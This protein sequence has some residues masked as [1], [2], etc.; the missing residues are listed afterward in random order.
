MVSVRVRRRVAVMARRLSVA[1]GCCA[2]FALVLGATAGA[3]APPPSKRAGAS[4]V[5]VG[6]SRAQRQLA[7]LAALR[8]GGVTIRRVVFQ[9]PSRVL[10]YEHVRGVELVVSSAG[11]RT[12]RAEWEQ[13]LY[14]GAYLGLMG[15]WPKAA[16][17][18]A[19]TD[20]TEG[21]VG[22]L[23]P[24]EVFGS[25]PCAAAVQR[26]LVPLSA[27]ASRHGAR[28]VELRVAATPAR[29]IAL[30]LRVSDPAAFLKHWT[31]PVLRLLE[32][33]RIPLLGYY[34]GV[35]EAS[36]RLVFATSRLPDTGAVFVIPS[37]DACS[38]VAHGEPALSKPPPCPAR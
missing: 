10:R 35:Q 20:Q 31:S 30:T 38:P 4:V 19:A 27:A 6:G 7:R 23:R 15:R 17:A 21:P 3:G 16:V 24:Y 26:E 29:T 8:V 36:G 13:Q 14:V 12:L 33:P 37:L 1:V 11:N 34:L 28:V 5:I 22:R 32:R 2:V 18:A 25:N 9:H